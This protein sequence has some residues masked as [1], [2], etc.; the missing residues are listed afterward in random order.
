MSAFVSD[1]KL[2]RLNCRTF[3]V[4]VVFGGPLYFGNSTVNHWTWKSYAIS[5][6]QNCYWEYNTSVILTNI[7]TWHIQCM[8]AFYIWGFLWQCMNVSMHARVS[9]NHDLHPVSVCSNEFRTSLHAAFKFAVNNRTFQ[10]TFRSAWYRIK[11]DP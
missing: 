7:K 8:S 3:R 2:C 9:Q 11:F 10:L 1:N 6:A 5:I 4:A